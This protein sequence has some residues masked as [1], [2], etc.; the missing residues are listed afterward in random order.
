MVAFSNRLRWTVVKNRVWSAY[1]EVLR[2]FH[3]DRN[4]QMGIKLIEII[5]F[6]DYVTWYLFRID[7]FRTLVNKWT[8]KEIIEYQIEPSF[9]HTISL[10]T[11]GKSK[12][13]MRPF[14]WPFLDLFWTVLGP[15]QGFLSPLTWTQKS[16][17]RLLLR[18]S[19]WT[20]P[21]HCY[22]NV[23]LPE[24]LISRDVIILGNEKRGENKKIK[25]SL[26][27]ERGGVFSD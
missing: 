17:L 16:H 24:S 21:C 20:L 3:I 22:L 18:Q 5:L 8:C 13:K 19:K 2:S 15:F 7:M 10:T 6:N 9:I 14:F 25:R 23:F 27:M 11:F 1:N 26:E 12:L 4:I